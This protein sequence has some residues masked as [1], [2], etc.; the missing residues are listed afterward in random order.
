ML[1]W[2]IA[3][4][5]LA[6][7]TL[8]ASIW[9]G[10][11]NERTAKRA[12]KQAEAAN[13]L[14]T[15]RSVV[16]WRVQRSNAD[17]AGRFRVVNVGHDTAYEV[18]VEAWD[19][20]ELVTESVSSLSPAKPGSTVEYVEVTLKRR[21]ESGPDVEDA[22]KRF[23]PIPEPKEIPGFPPPSPVAQSVYEHHLELIAEQIRRQVQ[24]KVTWRSKL[25]RWSNERMW[26][27]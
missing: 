23:L 14:A 16:E 10:S 3:A 19:S 7:L 20:H 12:L 22:E 21:S 2:T 4:A 27:G 9:F 17:D 8:I 24:V 26:T 15:E 1:K 13:Q 18:T 11:R 25:G 5:V 6:C